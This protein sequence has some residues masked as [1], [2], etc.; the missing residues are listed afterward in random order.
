MRKARIFFA[1]VFFLSITGLFC[2]FTATLAGYA[3]WMAKL[4]LVP[5][6]LSV[7]AVSIIAVLVLT[8]LMG[9]VYCSVICPLGILQDVVIFCRRIFG[10]KS[11]GTYPSQNF[12][13]VQSVMR[14]GFLGMFVAG[15]FLGLHFVWLEP[16]AIY[17][18][19]ASSLFAPLYREGNNVLASW[20]ANN[21]S[22]LFYAVDVVLPALGVMVFSISSLALLV[23]LAAWKGRV[24]C[25]TV[26]PVGTA[27]GC[28]SRFALVRPEIDGTNCG[29]CKMC[30]RVC[31][32]QCIS[33]DA[34]TIDMS[35][36]VACYDC[37]KCCPKSTIKLT[38]K[39]PMKK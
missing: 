39:K 2:D 23:A 26:C 38:V 11:F 37:L 9:R 22:Y 25:N 12:R 4:Q 8:V 30:E 5:A 16:Y 3:S 21:S 10:F 33:V 35:R 13:K 14:Y 32:A 15:G 36:C 28:V 34:K 29:G 31:K 19:I 1:S 6:V 18:R 7:S 27:L 17:G 20:A 24:W